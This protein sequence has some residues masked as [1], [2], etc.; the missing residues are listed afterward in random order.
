MSHL[1]PL[2]TR[3]FQHYSRPADAFVRMIDAGDLNLNPTYQRGPRW[4]NARR[5]QL[6]H[7]ILVE[8]PIPAVVLGLRPDGP[9][10]VSMTASVIDGKQRIQTL[11]DWFHDE[12]SVPA[13]WFHEDVIENPGATVTFHDLTIKGQRLFCRR[14]MLPTIE[15]EFDTEA[16]E[17]Q[18]YL[19]LNTE[20]VAH[21]EA[22]LARAAAVADA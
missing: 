2:S 10:A 1:T 20:G 21:T 8:I 15:A 16:E 11:Y 19:L 17:A 18:L 6:I 14:A 4:E 13:S 5:V 9:G 22:D 3:S 7:S 12:L